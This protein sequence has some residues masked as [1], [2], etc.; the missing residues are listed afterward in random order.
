MARDYRQA[1]S[2][3]NSSC[4]CPETEIF[5]PTAF[6]KFMPFTKKQCLPVSF[7]GKII[8]QAISSLLIPVFQGIGQ[9]GFLETF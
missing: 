3:G 4:P 6:L 7:Y 2:G 1:K 8:F 9:A 5:T